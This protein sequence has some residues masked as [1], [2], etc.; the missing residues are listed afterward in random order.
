MNAEKVV[1]GN[2]KVNKNKLTGESRT[3]C[4]L[5]I[6][7]FH[8]AERLLP[9]RATSHPMVKNAANAPALRSQMFQHQREPKARHGEIS[10]GLDVEKPCFLVFA[11]PQKSCELLKRFAS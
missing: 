11:V 1:L 4:L 2:I 5:V 3:I 9:S 7:Y 8:I 10:C 6:I